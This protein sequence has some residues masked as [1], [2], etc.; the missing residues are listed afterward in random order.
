MM[1]LPINT[2]PDFI[3]EREEGI[4][5]NGWRCDLWKSSHEPCVNRKV[6]TNVETVV[7]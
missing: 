2:V 6:V 3:N 5:L 7:G 4:F 1:S